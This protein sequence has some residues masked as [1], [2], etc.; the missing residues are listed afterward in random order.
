MRSFR[1]ARGDPR[2]RNGEPDVFAGAAVVL[3]GAASAYVTGNEGRCP[4]HAGKDRDGSA[5]AAGHYLSARRL[6]VCDRLTA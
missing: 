2:G 1:R 5:L 6:T 3:A 4:G